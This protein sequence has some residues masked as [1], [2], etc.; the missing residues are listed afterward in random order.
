MPSR[1]PKP[2]IALGAIMALAITGPLGFY[3]AFQLRGNSQPA[4]TPVAQAT[5]PPNIISLAL[6]QVPD[7]LIPLDELS[8]GKLPDVNIGMLRDL[9]FLSTLELPAAVPLPGGGELK[10]PVAPL[11]DSDVE[12]PTL[13]P[14]LADK[15]TDA[16]AIAY[17]VLKKTGAIVK[18]ID[19]DKL[20]S[21]VALTSDTGASADSK[22]RTQAEDG[23][24]SPW[25]SPEKVDTAANDAVDAANTATEPIYVGVSKAVQILTPI[26][27]PT[28]GPVALPQLA[29]E[30][31]G[32]LQ[33]AAAEVGGAMQQLTDTAKA[34]GYIPAAASHPLQ[35]PGDAT[36]PDPAAAEAGQ[37]PAAAPVGAD[38]VTAVLID[39]GKTNAD[40]N[41][42]ATALPIG[43]NGPKVITRAQWGADESMRCATPDYDDSL[44]G[45]VVH[46][47]A[48]KNDY[49]KA[50][51]A[52][53]V[54]AIYAYHAK[55]L[56][57]CDIGYNV[58]VD[59]FGQIFEGR[60]GGLDRP[61]Q[62]AHAGGFN[63]NTMGI[64][65]MGDFETVAPPQATINA[66]G[67]FLGWRLAKAGLDPLGR[68]TMY[69]EGSNYTPYP[70]GKA[71]D[72]PIIFAHRDVGSTTCP[73]DSAYAKM[74]EIRQIAAQAA[75]G[76]YSNPTGGLNDIIGT[77]TDLLG[78]AAA[79]PVTQ[80]WEGTGGANGP[81]GDAITQ[82]LKTATGVD[83]AK[84]T[85]G[86]IYA[87]PQGAFAVLG[88]IFKAW[89]AAGGADGELGLPTS[90]EYAVPGGSRTDFSNGALIF[91]NVTGAVV[92]LI[93]TL[94]SSGL[95]DAASNALGNAV[96][97][98]AGQAATAQA[99]APRTG[100]G[101][102]AY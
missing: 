4:T 42:D 2:S 63:E 8:G 77:I 25:F 16:N 59:R 94:Q 79:S 80:K 57:W 52:G 29:G 96:G 11:A 26:V 69:S 10:L 48:G 23:T 50:E 102:P 68:T 6:E 46:H 33:G 70:K 56:G 88:E 12:P 40:N 31:G 93:G 47:T 53:I 67:Q 61:V 60:A 14:D 34:L 82:I 49:T 22:I 89:Q 66:V 91:N 18:Q 71:V 62:G 36:V 84:F 65:M 85:Q 21:M 95:I 98:A 1:R 45:A 78:T 72:L 28:P 44:G 24:W 55:T 81:L 37:A 75:Q 13:P 3:G 19:S 43:G 92:K 86:G 90:D 76:N 58:L 20:F 15:A 87:T 38:Q 54:R 101:I 74:N 83:Y 32:L 73:G 99:P 5:V 7:V 30:L 51:S 100:T 27:D 35:A 39:P 17:D 97:Q 41:F 64:S 9:P